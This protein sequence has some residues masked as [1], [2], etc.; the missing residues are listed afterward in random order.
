MNPLSPVLITACLPTWAIPALWILRWG[1][2]STLGHKP[3]GVAPSLW[4]LPFSL[5][6]RAGRRHSLRTMLPMPMTSWL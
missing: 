5:L 1:V 6:C 3:Q 4:L 2:V